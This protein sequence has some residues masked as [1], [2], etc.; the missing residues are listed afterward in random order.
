MKH[1]IATFLLF[2]LIVVWFTSTCSL[3]PSGAEGIILYVEEGQ[4]WALDVATNQSK[5]LT[6]DEGPGSRVF[7]PKW[8]PDGH[9][10]AYERFNNLWLSDRSGENQREIAEG[11]SGFWWVNANL[12]RYC[13]SEQ[14][15][16]R[17][18]LYNSTSETI[19]ALGYGSSWWIFAYS[20]DAKRALVQEYKL[21][22]EKIYPQNEQYLLDLETQENIFQH[23][24]GEGFWTEDPQWTPDGKKVA[25]TA[26]LSNDVTSGNIFVIGANGENLTQLTNFSDEE[27]LSVY[28]ALLRWSPDGEWL[29][30]VVATT[31]SNELAVLKADGSYLKRLKIEW[32]TLGQSNLPPVWSPDSKEI[33]FVSNELRQ[34]KAKWAVY[35]VNIESGNVSHLLGVSD[36]RVWLDWR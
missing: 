6:F 12:L 18:F 15:N 5:Q 35:T 29:A 11:I 25:F 36:F 22:D 10:F 8:S 4:I 28:P 23:K 33:A 20:P 24:I 9:I 16:I 2:C 14:L 19:T 32:M 30:F 17:C 34:E 27:D 21:I 26:K 7:T 31:A 13:Q 3:F 1:R